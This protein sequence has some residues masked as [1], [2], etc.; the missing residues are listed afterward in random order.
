M[1]MVLQKKSARSDSSC[2]AQVDG[3]FELVRFLC[4]FALQSEIINQYYH[5]YAT[6]H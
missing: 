2:Q 6:I 5:N 3:G 1:D 4:I